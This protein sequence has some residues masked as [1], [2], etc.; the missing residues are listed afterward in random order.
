MDDLRARTTLFCGALTFAIAL[1]VLLRGRRLIH[2]LFAGFATCVAG[3]YASQSLSALY[4]SQVWEQVTTVFT[5]LIPQFA[6]HV[7]EGTI[8]S[9]KSTR[10][11][12]VAMALGVP[13]FLLALSPYHNAPVSLGVIYSYVVCLFGA[14]LYMLHRRGQASR[15]R[16]IRDRVRF[17]VFV[18][19]LA[20]S[21]TLADFLSFLG[22]SLPPIGAVLAIV[23]VFVLAESLQRPRLAD[24]YELSGRLMVSTILAFALAGIFYGLIEY[25]GRAG[26]MYLNAVLAAIVFLVLVEPMRSE[27]QRRIHQ[28]FFRERY[29]LET[30]IAELQRKIAHTI[31][32]N[33]LGPVIMTGL[34]NSRRV[35]AAALYL[36]DPEGLERIATYGP[37]CPPRIDALALRPL[38]SRLETSLSLEELSRTTPDTDAPLHTAIAT[39]SALRSSY[40]VAIR[41]DD[42]DLI[43][44]L[45]VAD[46]RARDAFTPEE[47]ILLEALGA[48]I[49]VAISNTRIYAKLKER[50]RLAS[51]GAMAAGL[52]HEVKNPLGSIKGAAQLLEE[53]VY[54]A[55]TRE[56]LGIIIEET[57]R[58]NRVVGSFLD[59]ARPHTGNPVPLDINAAIRRATQILAGAESSPGLELKLD[60]TEELPYAT[61]DAEQFRQV[62][63]NLVQN[64]IQA[65]NREGTVTISTS[66]RPESF[67]AQPGQRFIEVSVHD[68][69]PGIAP[70]VLQNL[71]VPFFTTKRQGT[72]LGLAISQRIVQSAGGRIEV[73][74]E[75][76]R[77]ATFCMLLPASEE[78][79]LSVAPPSLVDAAT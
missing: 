64:S 60:L 65:V 42:K 78:K 74:N 47:V 67:G 21:F 1:S 25:V 28:F 46:E 10:F 26:A 45:A 2:F 23:F 29:D 71:F 58:L 40:V 4:H 54:D 6:L 32:L 11:T 30:S 8:E 62:L 22:V 76:G 50:D 18:G 59:Y 43:G 3:W 15:S 16:A 33:E 17:L 52:A 77:G 73:Q 63:I 38:L 24:L 37:E 72:G 49:S 68:T 31:E 12:K 5:V 61:L 44:L 41:S 56:F 39:M 9:T 7:F 57:D 69:G 79:L 51:L 55:S 70:G 34:E 36:R 66:T 14:S 27:I 35:T 48:Q 53:S 75:P 19:A 13:L 20:T